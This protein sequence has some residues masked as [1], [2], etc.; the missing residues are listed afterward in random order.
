MSAHATITLAVSGAPDTDA[1]VRERHVREK[2]ALTPAL[3]ER[4]S[5]SAERLAEERRL[6]LR[7]LL[8]LAKERSPWHRERLRE[9]DPESFEEAW[10]GQLPT[11]TKDDVMGSFDRI[12][13]DPRLTLERVE[14]HLASLGSEPAYLL[15]RYQAIASGGSTGRRGVF[16]YGW[17]AWTVNYVGW[18]RYLLRAFAG[19]PFTMALV[20]A[21]SATHVSS[22][23]L[24]TVADPAAIATSR[25]PVTLPFERI[26][27][28]LSELQPDVVL[29]YPTA[30]RQLTE[31]A[32]AGELRIAPRALVTG[33]EPLL[34]EIRAACREA[35]GTPV[36]NWW[37]SSEGGPMAIGCGHEA[38]LHLSDDLVV[39]EPVDRAGTAVP[40]GVRSDKVYLTNLFNDALPLIRYELTDEVTLLDGTCPCGSAHR[41]IEDVQGRLDDSFVFP[42]GL[43]VHPHIFRSPLGRERGIVEYQVRQTERGAAIVVCCA[44][45]VD[46]ATLRR[47]VVERLAEVGLAAPEVTIEVVERLG[48]QTSGKLRRFVPLAQ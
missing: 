32:E 19:R 18:F 33:G 27:A 16:V 48:R 42:G 12:V 5:W 9:V 40:A 8:R 20:A 37:L 17:D 39:I 24:R 26:C 35:W 46:L 2:R 21:G 28:E 22:A 31:A 23:L 10:L 1:A 6:R 4:I 30:L 45:E 47:A 41:L 29:A 38:G 11:M 36:Q 44:S 25:V 14:E 13:T 34:A 15:G 43:V 7:A 3:V